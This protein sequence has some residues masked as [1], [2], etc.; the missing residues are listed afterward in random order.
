M[1]RRKNGSQIKPITSLS[2]LEED[3]FNLALREFMNLIKDNFSHYIS[4]SRLTFL[5]VI[6]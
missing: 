3:K 6:L 4:S 2:H 1:R 5:F